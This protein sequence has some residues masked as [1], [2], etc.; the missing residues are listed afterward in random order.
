MLCPGQCV[1]LG[2]TDAFLPSIH[3]REHL[4]SSLAS[5]F[6]PETLSIKYL[7]S[8]PKKCT[9]SSS[10][11]IDFISTGPSGFMLLTWPAV[12][13][14][15]K[16]TPKKKPYSLCIQRCT[17]SCSYVRYTN[18]YRTERIVTG[19]E[20]NQSIKQV[21]QSDSLI[22]EVAG[23]LKNVNH[24]ATLPESAPPFEGRQGKAAQTRCVRRHRVG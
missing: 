9:Y 19:F 1:C 23:M 20:I 18:V 5:E 7:L 4:L 24:R 21:D 14:S 12:N 8:L 3:F 17:A 6:G 15:G 13:A 11:C 10:D 2:R 22:L 16:K